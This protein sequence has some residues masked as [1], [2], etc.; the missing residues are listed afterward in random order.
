MRSDLLTCF[1]L[2]EKDTPVGMGTLAGINKFLSVLFKTNAK[3]YK[4]GN[5]LL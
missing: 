2:V 5:D 1:V 4:I 3:G